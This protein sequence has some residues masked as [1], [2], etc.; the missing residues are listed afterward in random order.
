MARRGGLE[1]QH[2]LH[3]AAGVALIRRIVGIVVFLAIVFW[4][5]LWGAMG[6][7]LAVPLLLVATTIHD[8][9]RTAP[10]DLPG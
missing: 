1:R 3:W 2:G 8:E 5:W 4:T 10:P 9:F 7:V 6:A